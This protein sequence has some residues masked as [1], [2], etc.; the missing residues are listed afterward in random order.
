MSTLSAK[1]YKTLKDFHFL[2]VP[3]FQQ[4]DENELKLF[5]KILNIIANKRHCT[6]I[7]GNQLH[8]EPISFTF[9]ALRRSIYSNYYENIH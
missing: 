5:S 8:V 4:I 3:I 2:R 6:V 1:L 9:H 7:T